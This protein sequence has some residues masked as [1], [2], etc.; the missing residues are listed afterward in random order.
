MTIKKIGQGGVGGRGITQRA[1][2][3]I[4][5]ADEIVAQLAFHAKTRTD[6][7]PVAIKKA[8][9]TL[10]EV[11]TTEPHVAIEAEASKQTFESRNALL[12]ILGSH[13]G[14]GQRGLNVGHVAGQFGYA[15]LFL[16][17][18]GLH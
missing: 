17:R 15:I 3:Q 2:C 18:R 6:A 16:S 9:C 1:A 5:P 10:E 14:I 4:E 11:L 13:R 12:L 8:R 7:T